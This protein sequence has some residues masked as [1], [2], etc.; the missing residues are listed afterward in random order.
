MEKT[1]LN[2]HLFDKYESTISTYFI[3]NT[4]SSQMQQG[5]ETISRYTNVK[6]IHVGGL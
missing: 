4:D 2:K 1:L 3:E 6:L 5:L